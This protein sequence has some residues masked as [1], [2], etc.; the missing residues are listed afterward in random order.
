MAS[1]LE[2]KKGIFSKICGFWTIWGLYL[3]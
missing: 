1:S 2:R 3:K